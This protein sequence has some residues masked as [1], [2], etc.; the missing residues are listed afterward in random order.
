[1]AVLILVILVISSGWYATNKIKVETFPNMSFPALFVQATYMNHSAS[2][3]ED[4][5]TNPLEDSIKQQRGYDTLTST[6]SNNTANISIMYPFGTDMDKQKTK[7]DEAVSKVKVPDG[8]KVEVKKIDTSAQAVYEVA[9]SANDSSQDTQKAIED[10]LVPALEKIEGVGTVM[11]QGTKT[12]KIS[13]EVDQDKAKEYGISLQTIKSAIQAKNYKVSLGQV[14]QDGT[15]IPLDL[16][17]STASSDDIKNIE[18]SGGQSSQQATTSYTQGGSGQA[19]GLAMGATQTAGAASQAIGSTIAAEKVKLSDIATVKDATDQTEISRF[20]GKESFLISVTKTQDANTAQVVNLV[21]DKITE[22]QKSNNVTPYTVQDQGKDV[23]ESISSLL[24]EG[25]YGILFAVIIILLF[26]RNVRATVIA[27]ISLPLSIL[28]TISLLQQTDYTLNIMTLGGMAIAVGRIIDD[29]IVVIENIFRWRQEK[30]D[31]FSMKQ[32]AFYATK[33]VMRAVTGSTLTTL[34]VFI[35]IAFVSGMIGQIFRPFALAVVFSI[36]VSLLVALLVI[37]ILGSMFFKRVKPAKKEGK[38]VHWY[39]SLLRVS[40]R[41]KW[42]VVLL[43]VLLLV[44]SLSM[45]PKLGVSF[46]PSSASTALQAE[47]DVP[48]SVNV[49]QM[50]DIAK[51]TESYLKD[52]KE[53][54]YSQVSIGLS[55]DRAMFMGG[56]SKNK[57]T[58]AI[59]LNDKENADSYISKYQ[60]NIDSLSKEKNKDATVT[61]TESQQGGVSTGNNI[62]IQLY[63]S[64]MNKLTDASN[65]VVKMLEK[66]DKLKNISSNVSD[67]QTK[68]KL[69]IN[70]DGN[71]AG[72][73]YTTLMQAV[74]EYLSTASVGQY[75]VNGTKQEVTI[76]YNKQITS[77]DDIKNIEVTTQKGK[78]TVGDIADLTEVQVPSTLYHDDGNPLVKISAVVKGNDT[79]KVSQSVQ[80][81]V[82]SLSLPS[83]VDVKFGGGL[84]MI[85]DGF[86]SMG[87]AM[88]AAIGF[89]FLVLSFT[90][91]GILTPIVI[92]SS[93]IFI[94]VGALGGLLISGQSLSMSALIGLLMLI[95]IVVSNAVVLLDRVETNRKHGMELVESIVEAAKT[96]LRPI[97]MTAFATV[98]ALVPLALS[99][100]TNGLISKGLAVTV[101]GGLT[102]ST[103]LTLI[104]VPVLYAMVGKFRKN[105]S[106]DL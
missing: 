10:N 24:K 28:A 55:N 32:T 20:N 63:S 53:I 15:N 4:Q 66:N 22:F 48:N 40:L 83:G 47:I 9:L 92:L 3:L 25:G 100:S 102:T 71:K 94:P 23:N 73:S 81:D 80:Q 38:L 13:I 69:A 61:V 5:L 74:N 85:S 64:D 72:V 106:D 33:E 59:Q 84:K 96:R 93:L 42:V 79:A 89:V 62:D 90:F 52:Q 78:K 67:G 88:G 36:A 56:S 2:E 31:E 77:K 76:N 8:A 58:F 75:E 35:P 95:G 103:L 82:K 65:T 91:G 99:T 87:L 17:G 101:I 45:I 86:S 37:P 12:H 70:D 51:Q 97:L 14:K 46:L 49:N 34:V 104:F 60:K 57:I 29:S 26:L 54:K 27:M 7:L 30:G 18:I 16:E 98:F 105:L 44:G 19:A 50:D 11:V 6:S 68:W 1:M 39:E 43:S 41:R 21:R